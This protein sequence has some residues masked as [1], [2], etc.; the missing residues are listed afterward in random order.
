ME[1]FVRPSASIVKSPPPTLKVKLIGPIASKASSTIASPTADVIPPPAVL[2]FEFKNEPSPFIEIVKS[3]DSRTLISAPASTAK[4]VPPV[5]LSMIC[6]Y[7]P[8][9]NAISGSITY[10]VSFLDIWW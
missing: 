8:A 3:P 1:P 4:R 9:P 10:S 5:W 7:S 6:M 2:L